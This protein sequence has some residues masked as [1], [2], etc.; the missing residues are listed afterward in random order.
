MINEGEFLKK[1]HDNFDRLYKEFH[2]AS[3]EVLRDEVLRIEEQVR[4][5]VGNDPD[6]LR[7]SVLFRHKE[8]DT[9]KNWNF[10]ST[11]DGLCS[12]G[13]LRRLRKK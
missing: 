10:N 11:K 8:E 5:I 3:F 12:I 2:K 4:S 6:W 7:P 13:C 1:K 9:K